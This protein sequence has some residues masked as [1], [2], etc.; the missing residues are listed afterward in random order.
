[1]LSPISVAVDPRNGDLIIADQGMPRIRRVFASNGTITTI[2][3]NGSTGDGLGRNWLANLGRP[4]TATPIGAPAGVAVD[5]D[6]NVYFAANFASTV[7]RV[8]AQTGIITSVFVPA[9][10]NYTGGEKRAQACQPMC[11]LSALAEHPL[12]WGDPVVPSCTKSQTQQEPLPI[13]SSY[14]ADK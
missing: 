3:G 4:A 1:M 6:G 7:Y 13:S 12:S 11:L 9:V 8:D 14:K 5:R 2:A 10:Q